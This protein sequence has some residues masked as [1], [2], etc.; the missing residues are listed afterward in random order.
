MEYKETSSLIKVGHDLVEQKVDYSSLLEV[1]EIEEI[2]EDVLEETKAMQNVIQALKSIFPDS[3][4]Y[5][6]KTQIMSKESCEVLMKF[7]LADFFFASDTFE[8]LKT[9]ILHSEKDLENMKSCNFLE[10]SFVLL[11]NKKLFSFYDQLYEVLLV[12]CKN[13]YK[14][15]NEFYSDS[16]AEELINKAATSIISPE[17]IETDVIVISS[18][19][20]FDIRRRIQCSAMN[21]LAFVLSGDHE[22]DINIVVLNKICKA[23]ILNDDE[24]STPIFRASLLLLSKIMQIIELP[25][26][27]IID[28]SLLKRLVDIYFHK[29]ALLDKKNGLVLDYLELVHVIIIYDKEER[30]KINKC[31]FFTVLTALYFRGYDTLH[32]LSILVSE[33]L[34]DYMVEYFKIT[35]DQIHEKDNSSKTATLL[36]VFLKNISQECMSTFFNGNFELI[37]IMCESLNGDVS[38]WDIEQIIKG[39][40]CSLK[41]A[42]NAG[43]LED[44]NEASPFD[45]LLENVNEFKGKINEECDA[46]IDE[47]NDLLQDDGD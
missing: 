47:I 33:G 38:H 23:F 41:Y 35:L 6:L 36:G 19:L 24:Y 43:V 37:D 3:Q 25:N 27:E 18:K 14:D 22:I 2:T 34:E 5:E 28:D 29:F 10:W 16:F 26:E 45:Q 1:D 32:D 15:V 42:S 13:A 12:F 44:V 30:Q 7:P 21:F 17:S 11:E 4:K 8:I 31:G 46:A 39:I 40:L 9:L 20:D